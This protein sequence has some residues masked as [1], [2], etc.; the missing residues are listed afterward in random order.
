MSSCA[1]C[2]RPAVAVLCRGCVRQMIVA[3]ARLADGPVR[4][5]RARRRPL[6]HRAC[7][8]CPVVAEVYRQGVAVD[9]IVERHPGLLADL[10]DVVVQRT[11]VPVGIDRLGDD[12]S[13]LPWH[14][15]ASDLAQHARTVLTGWV[16]VLLD[17]HPAIASTLADTSTS[18]VARW[19]ARRGRTLA[20]LPAAA[21]AAQDIVDL[22]RRVAHMVDR[23]LER[24][25][26]GP[27][28]A[29]RIQQDRVVRCEYDLY[30]RPDRA[31]VL[32]QACHTEHDIEERREQLRERLRGL[33]A[34]AAEISRAMP[35]LIGGDVASS[36]IRRWVRERGLT[37][38]PPDPRDARRAV[39]Y[40]VDDVLR[41]AGY[42]LP[43]HEEPAS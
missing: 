34:T 29:L 23:A 27:C 10:E 11:R 43:E 6:R 36:T 41:L 13:R 2:Q 7:G 25:F 16:R 33:L 30:G 24:L 20:M 15:E 21:E 12:E 26:L 31:T 1:A 38:Y 9:V 4:R 3:L 42:P 22:H 14:E 37:Q 8:P 19:L 32:C 18:G 5:T 39:R 35:S 40:R 17:D 28:G